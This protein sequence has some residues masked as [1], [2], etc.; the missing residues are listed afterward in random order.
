[1]ALVYSW[2]FPLALFWSSN[3]STAYLIIYLF[4]VEFEKMNIESD[5]K[6]QQQYDIEL[7]L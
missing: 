2:L 5:R 6:N 4:I 7:L 1:M 3:N